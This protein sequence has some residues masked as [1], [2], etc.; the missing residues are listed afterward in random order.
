MKRGP[1]RLAGSSDRGGDS[2]TPRTAPGRAP[3]PPLAPATERL[4]GLL[5]SEGWLQE[6]VARRPPSPRALLPGGWTG[7]QHM[8]KG[9]P[10]RRWAGYRGKARGVG[11][12][13]ALSG[14]LGR[15]PSQD[16][17]RSWQVADPEVGLQS[18][19][20]AAPGHRAR[21]LPAAEERSQPEMAQARPGSGHWREAAPSPGPGS[22]LG[23]GRGSVP[24]TLDPVPD[25][26]PLPR[27][28]LH[29]QPQPEAGVLGQLHLQA[30]AG[31]SAHDGAALQGRETGSAPG[32]VPTAPQE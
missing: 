20:P 23:K 30:P 8:Q 14:V 13:P 32:A 28:P 4:G 17:P 27:A 15:R 1:Q 2:V 16:G 10:S 31:V 26:P 21:W 29:H 7:P 19:V 11:P 6:G 18:G 12:E 3:L 24:P 5:E 9:W 25:G 22:V